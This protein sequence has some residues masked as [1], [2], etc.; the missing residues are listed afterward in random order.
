VWLQNINDWNKVS[1]EFGNI[2][3][4]IAKATTLIAEH[5]PF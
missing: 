3:K 1:E 4:Q 5:G 2:N